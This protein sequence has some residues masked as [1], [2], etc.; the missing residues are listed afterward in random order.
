MP[1][2]AGKAALVVGGSRGIGAAV[3]RRLAAE[4]ASVAVGFRVA[5]TEADVIVAEIRATG[6]Q[7]AA[8]G[9]NIADAGAAAGMVGAAHAAFGCLDILV[10]TAGVG[11]YR[12]LAAV[13]EDYVRTIFDT[14][15]L[16][17]IM[18]TKA[19]ADVLRRPGG[20]I[21]HF[22]SRLAYS[23]IPTSTV[24]AA[25]KAAVVALTHGYAKELGPSGITVNAVAPGVIET[26]MTTGII[27]ER[28]DSI[29]SLTPLGR[30]GQP[31]DIAGIVAFLAS[32]DA[33]WI[34][35]RTIIADG[36]YN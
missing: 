20:R 22:A 18:L 6:G 7:A 21:V 34:T 35:G 13:D 26:D 25:S 11:P 4:G 2:L 23:P 29:R 33:G 36:G 3:A 8:F 14:N 32:D 31:D 28:G 10:N 16:G 17:A 30:I 9:G 24:Y 1:R 5:S 19:A 27:A 15:V 12:P